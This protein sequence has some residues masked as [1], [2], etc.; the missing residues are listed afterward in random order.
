MRCDAVFDGS[1][2]PSTFAYACSAGGIEVEKEEGTYLLLCV[3]TQCTLYRSCG[4][5]NIPCRQRSGPAANGP[6]PVSGS[7]VENDWVANEPVVLAS[8]FVGGYLPASLPTTQP[9]CHPPEQTALPRIS[10]LPAGPGTHASWLNNPALRDKTIDSGQ[11]LRGS[12]CL[13][14]LGS[15]LGLSRTTK[16]TRPRS[17]RTRD[18]ADR[19][20]DRWA[21]PDP[22][23]FVPFVCVRDALNSIPG[24]WW[25]RLMPGSRRGA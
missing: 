8:L 6:W 16:R 4:V 13:W 20:L 12:R 22:L 25:R 23:R 18:K 9:P 2:G 17:G 1:L 5:R 11:N 19:G 14:K 3:G 21:R 7:G 10:S 15:P 24:L